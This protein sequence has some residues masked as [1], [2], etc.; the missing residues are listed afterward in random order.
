MRVMQEYE[1]HGVVDQFPRRQRQTPMPLS[2]VHIELTVVA[3]Q[4]ALC[5][6]GQLVCLAERILSIG[7][8]T[9]VR[10]RMPECPILRFLARQQYRETYGTRRIFRPASYWEGLEI[11]ANWS[12]KVP[13][14]TTR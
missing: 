1:E 7:F 5:S 14:I 3:Q 13:H 6:V 12:F 8:R 2:H 11:V 9:I 4:P 10:G